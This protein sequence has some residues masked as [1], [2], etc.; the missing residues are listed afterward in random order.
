MSWP[1]SD[2]VTISS[3]TRSS[4][5]HLIKIPLSHIPTIKLRIISRHKLHRL[6]DKPGMTH[7]LT[8]IQNQKKKGTDDKKKSCN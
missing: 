2:L 7:I 6:C 4:H 8:L 5:L 3:H 1:D